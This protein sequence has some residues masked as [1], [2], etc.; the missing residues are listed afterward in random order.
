M[1]AAYCAPHQIITYALGILTDGECLQL[2]PPFYQKDGF[3]AVK[4]KT[5]KN[6]SLLI[7]VALDFKLP[8]QADFFS[9]LAF[10]MPCR[11]ELGSYKITKV[12]EFLEFDLY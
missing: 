10:K 5:E 12:Q 8:Q 4:A 1:S 9:L 2:E 3:I 7:R 11:N 6:C